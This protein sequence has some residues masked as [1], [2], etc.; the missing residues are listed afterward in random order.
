MVIY[1]PS[2][3]PTAWGI[4]HLAVPIFILKFSKDGS[5]YLGDKLTVGGVANQ[6]VVLKGGVGLSSGQVSPGVWYGQFE[7]NFQW[8]PDISGRLFDAVVNAFLDEVKKAGG[9]LTKF[10]Y[11]LMS[12]CMRSASRLL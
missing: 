7:S 11:R 2:S 8:L 6:L 5:E 4:F 1:F 3:G 9:I 12:V 10:S